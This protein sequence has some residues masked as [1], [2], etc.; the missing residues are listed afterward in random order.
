MRPLI[1]QC[2]EQPAQRSRQT[3]G[4]WLTQCCQPFTAQLLG[5]AAYRRESKASRTAMPASTTPSTQRCTADHSGRRASQPVIAVLDY[6]LEQALAAYR[7]VITPM[8]FVLAGALL[9]AHR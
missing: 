9:A 3:C 8:L 1:R 5:K 4:I 2:H 7:A 6:P